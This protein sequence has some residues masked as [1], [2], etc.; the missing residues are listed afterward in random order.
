[1][2]FYMHMLS[3]MVCNLM[4]W[5]TDAVAFQRAAWGKCCTNTK[6]PTEVR[7]AI[8]MFY[9]DYT[10]TSFLFSHFHANSA[11]GFLA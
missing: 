4:S 6:S 2:F 5:S 3:S 9:L 8:R 7:L 10:D 11:N 1:M